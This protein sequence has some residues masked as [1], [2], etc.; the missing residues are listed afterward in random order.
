M[1]GEPMDRLRLRAIIIGSVLVVNQ[2]AALPLAHA[3]KAVGTVGLR[4][5]Q[6]ASPAIARGAH[7]NTPAVIA[8]VFLV[9]QPISA[10]PTRWY[11]H[12]EYFVAVTKRRG[13]HRPTDWSIAHQSQT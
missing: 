7:H 12:R 13:P 1:E 2:A 10:V 4:I 5:Y 9:F 11:F 3:V 6:Y 8:Q